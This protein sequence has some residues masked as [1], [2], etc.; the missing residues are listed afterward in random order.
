MS[1][2]FGAYLEDYNL[3]KLIVP[4]SV[5]LNEIILKDDYTSQKLE[6]K[7]SEPYANELHLFLEKYPFHNK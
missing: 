6:I 2:V 3:I 5:N 4:N 1:K 7:S